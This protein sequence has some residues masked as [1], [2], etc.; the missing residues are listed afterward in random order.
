MKS[1]S[2]VPLSQSEHTLWEDFSGS[3][4]TAA[5]HSLT[6][7]QVVS[8]F[9]IAVSFLKCCGDHR[10]YKSNITLDLEKHVNTAAILLGYPHQHLITG[11]KRLR[12][13]DDLNLN[14][15][16]QIFIDYIK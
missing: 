13:L 16:Q 3:V 5:V 4:A 11:C 6:R 2:G 12:V 8:K 15:I 10:A 1:V 14:F 7:F 9:V